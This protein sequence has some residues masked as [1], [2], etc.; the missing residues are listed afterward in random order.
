[1]LWILQIVLAGI[2]L[3]S[4]IFKSTHS[5]KK[6]ISIGQTGVGPLPMPLVR[7]GAVCEL[8]GAVG[9]LLPWLTGI[10]PVLT[11]L[12][13]VGFAIIMVVA[14]GSHIYLRE[15]RNTL[16]TI[17][18]LVASVLVAVGRFGMLGG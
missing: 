16:A 9:I 5:K 14:I 1:M 12:A 10:A 18:I 11:P 17:G 3:T 7:F 13:A 4:G 2:F 15:L 6:L 8:F